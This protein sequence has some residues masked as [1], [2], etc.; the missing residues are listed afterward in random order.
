MLGVPPQIDNDT[1]QDQADQRNHFDAGKPE[2]EFSE[3]SDTKKVDEKN[4]NRI[5]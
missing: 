2:F 3:H 5:K 1:E 4:W